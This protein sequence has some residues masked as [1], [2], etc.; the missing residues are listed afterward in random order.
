MLQRTPTGFI[1]PAFHLLLSARPPDPIGSF[2][3]FKDADHRNPNCS[4]A[5]RES[6][7]DWSKG[8]WW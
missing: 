6:E 4:A 7:D 1:D 2:E 8:K 5:P 3:P